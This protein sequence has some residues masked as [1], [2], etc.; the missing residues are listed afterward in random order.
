MEWPNFYGFIIPGFME[1]PLVF[2]WK[3][4]LIQRKVRLGLPKWFSKRDWKI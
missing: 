4:F 1:I 3:T 2:G